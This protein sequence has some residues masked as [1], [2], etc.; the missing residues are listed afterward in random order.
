M[1]RTEHLH[2]FQ[3]YGIELEYMIV[4]RSTL[5][6]RPISDWLLKAAGAEKN[7]VLENEVE[8][9]DMAWSN[10]LVMHVIE[11]K[12]NG[13]TPDLTALGRNFQVEIDRVNGLLAPQNAQLMPTAMHPFFDPDREMKLWT[14]DSREIYDAYNR[15]FDCRGHGWSNLQSVHVN[16]PFFDAE[17]A[18]GEFGKLHAAVRLVLPILPALAASSPIYGGRPSGIMDNRLEFYR[19]NQRAVPIITGGVIPEQAFTRADYDARIFQEIYKDIAPHDPDKILQ[20]EWL[21]SRGAIARFDRNAVEIRVLDIQETPKADQ[22]VITATVGAVKGLVEGA[23]APLE[24]QQAWTQEPL[25]KIFDACLKAGGEALIEDRAY[26]DA[27]HYP[28]RTPALAKDLWRHITERANRLE[29][30]PL[31]AVETEL[32]VLLGTGCLARRILAETGATPDAAAIKAVYKELCACLA[33]GRM[34]GV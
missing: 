34:F 24:K 33:G 1:S 8:F 12:T 20:E 18:D 9:G 2:L 17:A 13:P 25:R 11:M 6:V 31:G 30:V 3:G 23:F 10:E 7:G 4:D 26:L 27:F 21:N 14:H 15:I 32:E 19:G 28:G 29:L 5:A 16:L 22:A